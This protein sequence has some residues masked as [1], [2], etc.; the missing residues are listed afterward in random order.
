MW[1][2][3]LLFLTLLTGGLGALAGNLWP[4][5]ASADSEYDAAAYADADFRDIVEKVDGDFRRLRLAH[6]KS[7]AAKATDLA[8]MR[9]LALALMGTIPSLEEIR[10][11]EAQPEADRLPWWIER[12]LN[13]RR[14]SDYLAER[15]ARAAVGTEEGPFLFFRRRRLVDWLADQILE[16]RPY[17]ELV[18]ELISSRGLWTNQPAV[19]FV[20]ATSQQDKGNQPDPVR[21]AGRVSRAFLGIRLDCAECHNHPFANWKRTDFEGLSAFFG[22]TRIG[23][24]GVNDRGGVYEIKDRTTQENRIVEPRVP[25]ANELLPGDGIPRERLAAWATHP[26]NAAFA[27]ATVNRVWALLFGRPLV[28]PVDN[29]ES[30]AALPP[31][32]D[33]LADDFVTHGFDLRRLIRSI[34]SLEVYQ[35]QSEA[36]GDIGDEDEKVWAVFPLARLRPEQIVGSVIQASS[37]NTIDRDSHILTRIIRLANQKEFVERYGDRGEDEFEGRGGTIPQ[38]LLM[39]NGSLIDERIRGGPF[40]SSTRIAWFARPNATAVE[41]AYLTVL[42]RRPTPAEA[43]HFEQSLSEDRGERPHMLEDLFWSLVN[44]TEFSWNH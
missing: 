37:V 44:S 40:N 33:R 38:R 7:G 20:S 13:D 36:D 3:N 10:R 5:T 39:M 31:A 1:K 4:D 34:A 8:I 27:R 12:I 6:G 14:S 16:N 17:D 43:Q 24:T 2:R 19:N 32:L 18:R 25:Y 41:V 15:F 28:E 30:D 42:T 26:R 11:F 21:L 22:P 23:F 35:Q 29:L 9:R